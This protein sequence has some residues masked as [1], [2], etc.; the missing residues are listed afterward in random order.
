MS[1]STAATTGRERFPD[2]PAHMK[3]LPR[4]KRGFPVP[5]FVAWVGKDPFFPAIDPLKLHA[6]VARRLCWVCGN[7]LGKFHASVI[8]PMCAINRTVSEP[9]SHLE[10]ARF[11]AMH[12]PFLANPHMRRVPPR[13]YPGG[14][15]GSEPPG[16][17]L[18]RNPGACAVWIESR[19]LLPFR[20]GDGLLFE[21]GDPERVEWY[22]EGRPA[23]RSEVAASIESGLPALVEACEMEVPSKRAAAR[24][25]LEKLVRR[26]ME[27]IEELP[28]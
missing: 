2:L 22:C 10:C 12:C 26:V 9:P 14:K 3:A 27:M 15:R 19:A 25:E 24:L 1:K 18:E 7:P 8:G 6:A 23:L 16:I 13:I 20:V 11:S 28:Q 5:W 4:D 17:H 21:L